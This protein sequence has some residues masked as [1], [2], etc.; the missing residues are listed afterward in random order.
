MVESDLKLVPHRGHVHMVQRVAGSS[1]WSGIRL[2][3]T[4]S[5]ESWTILGGGVNVHYSPEGHAFLRSGDATAWLWPLSSFSVWKGFDADL[6]LLEASSGV[7][8]QISEFPQQ[9]RDGRMCVKNLRDGFEDVL[10][11]GACFKAS[12]NGSRC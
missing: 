6:H 7:R 11:V 2:T 3:H 5:G 8:Q 12:P 9:R 10:I 1:E 4:V